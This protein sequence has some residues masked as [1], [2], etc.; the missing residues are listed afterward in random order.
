MTYLDAIHT[1]IIVRNAPAIGGSGRAIIII[2][3]DLR[4]EQ[5]YRHGANLFYNTIYSSSPFSISSIRIAETGMRVPGPKI[6][7]TPAL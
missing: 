2:W 7:A 5:V 3:S 1:N 6:A 4:H